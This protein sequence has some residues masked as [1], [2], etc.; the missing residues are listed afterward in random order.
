MTKKAEIK[1]SVRNLVEFILRSGNIDSQFM[2]NASALEGT[3]AHQKIQKDNQDKGY[4]P[5]VS[6]KYRT[7]YQGF[8]F[9]IEGRADGI[10]TNDGAIIVDEIKST[11]R[12]L[13]QIDENYSE[14]HW[15][16]AKCY[17][18][19]YCVQNN[20]KTI[21]VQMTYYQL[22]TSELKQ[23]LKP[24]THKEL[25]SFFFNLIDQYL[26]WARLTSDWIT[27][28]DASIK[29][30]PFPFSSYR[31]GQ[32][33][34][35]VAVY[36]T[37]CDNKKLFVQA[38][39]GI[40]KT[41]STLFPAI[42]SMAE[43]HTA[44][45]FYLT[46]KTI[47]REVAEEAFSH[48]QEKGLAFKT[49]TLTAKD[50]ICFQEESICDP[51]HC[52]YAKGHFNRVN[53]AILD[54]L[55]QENTLTRPVI[56]N[57]AQKHQIC[58]FEFSLDLALWSD[59]VIC[60]YNY[61]FDP[62]VYLKRFFLDNGGDYTFL[63]D[64]AHNLV[65]RA[66]SMFSAE[67]YKK[68]VLALRRQFKDVDPNIA[69]TL[70]KINTYL[71]SLRKLAEINDQHHLQKEAPKELF[72]LLMKFISQAEE[73]LVK[74]EGHELHEKLLELY[75]NALTF[76]RT[77]EFYDKRYLTYV[78]NTHDDTKIKLFCLDPS[79][80]LSEAFKRGRA[81]IFFSATLSPLNYFSEILG[82]G[83]ESYKLCLASP[84]ETKNRELLIADTISTKFKNREKTAPAI[85]ECINTVLT[86]KQG[87]Y[88]VYFPSYKYMNEIHNLFVTT[89]PDIDT[90]KQ[91]TEMNED[92]REI[93]LN[94]FRLIPSDKPK[95]ILGFC[96]LG[97]IFSEGVDLKHEALIGAIIIG[98]GL[99][100][101]CFE[102]NII[103]DYFNAENNHGYEYSYLYPGMNKVLQA[104]GRVIRTETDQ[105]IIVLIDDRF[106]HQNYQQLFPQEWFPHTRVKNPKDLRTALQRFWKK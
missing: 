105:G 74:N 91:S 53:N 92:D 78:E 86:Q 5:E 22:E 88:I 96:V 95:A 89:Y 26:I 69:K 75:F 85:V 49:I 71:I 10:I 42:K 3:R 93:F 94:A 1:V 104:A 36:K 98:V 8:I 2:S 41:V 100:Q 12:P 24:F 87:N 60:D 50:K 59:C 65:D 21:G 4:Q 67:F 61:V 9:L 73:W 17:A 14:T 33:E 18:F 25:E 64:E 43:G 34:L 99:P 37:I 45:I 39:T 6:L 47:V 66:R 56:E 63:I 84:F 13:E 101:I 19:I 76:M 7:E 28:R 54:L 15:A 30:L 11:S 55:Q 40:G 77:S 103:R 82:G 32:R 81:A 48:M 20:I 72:P 52:Q 46:A 44:K 90:I 106:S 68:P 38:P 62:R 29:T 58:P 16:Q 35:A 102:R 97:G 27:K 70:G 57:Y 83:D 23:F 79:H 51:D 31:K 80:L